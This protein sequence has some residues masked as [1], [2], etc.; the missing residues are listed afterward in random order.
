MSCIKK[1]SNMT[2]FEELGLED[3]LLKAVQKLGFT[4]AMPV[5]SEVIPAMLADRSDIVA[6]AQTGTGKTAAFGLPLLQTLEP[7]TGQIQSVVLCPTRE[8]CL[9]IYG[10]LCDL[11]R[12]KKNLKMTAVYGGASI[13]GQIRDLE[14]KPQIIVAT[15]GRLL[16]MIRRG[17]AD[18]SA[19]NTLILDEADEMLN[20]GFAEE[21]NA[22]L[23]VTPAE[24]RVALFSATM[25]ADVARIS[26]QYM[27]T[28][29]EIVI[30]ER[31]AAS[32][33]LTH[34]V[35][36]ARP[37]D[38]Y[39]VVR[40]IIDFNPDIY[41]IVFCRTRQETRDMAERLWKDGYSADALHGDL[42][43]AQRETVMA[44][45]RSRQFPLL[46]ATDVAAR[47]IDV[48]D[49]SHVIHMNLPQDE[50]AYTH[51]SGRTGRAGKSGI[52]VLIALPSDRYR[53]QRMEK[54]LGVHFA[55]LPVPDAAAVCRKKVLA[56]L[57]NLEASV[58]D[59]ELIEPYMNLIE[60]RFEG[61][62]RN[63]LLKRWLTLELGEDLRRYRNAPDLNLPVQK[64]K[65]HTKAKGRERRPADSMEFSKL[66]VNL[67]KRNQL[68]PM[69]V[70]GMVADA[71]GKRNIE[72]G[73]IEIFKSFT[74]FEVDSS[75]ERRVMKGFETI[76]RKG[77][78]VRVSKVTGTPRAERDNL[79]RGKKN[80]RLSA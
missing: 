46:I 42:S 76:G 57:E 7:G 14:Q 66:M 53:L 11:G 36:L 18:L 5:Q 16:D 50:S 43:Q 48:S 24:K 30:G 34:E 2:T 59:S 69:A 6:L 29:Q 64:V 10:D 39:A 78:S 8:L 23:E 58:M 28:P 54:M 31:N 80:N 72:I 9:Q 63:E 4:Q 55:F 79:K 13:E 67:G 45:F 61:I 37:G 19:L 26:K 25:P 12:Y 20:M 3:V 35:Y 49:L 33:Q 41:A 21:L 60:S 65:P 32:G 22:I 40:R 70:M 62:G 71:T 44:R 56:R 52:S 38:R 27:R 77:A 68:N 74:L 17:K 15:P 1:R 47:G 75:E 51:R 73:R